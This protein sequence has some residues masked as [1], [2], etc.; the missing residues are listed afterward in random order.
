MQA[1]G[2]IAVAG[3]TGRVGRHIVD[4]L[5]VGG[6]DVVAMS[7][8]SRCLTLAGLKPLIYMENGLGS[9][10]SEALRRVKHELPP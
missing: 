2:K 9:F 10:I 3:A 5:K 6:H 8:S 4:V 7:R 1:G